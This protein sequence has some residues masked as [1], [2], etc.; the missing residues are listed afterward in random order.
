MTNKK[1]TLTTDRVIYDVRDKQ[2][3][4]GWRRRR[5]RSRGKE[6]HRRSDRVVRDA[7]APS[8]RVALWKKPRVLKT[9]QSSRHR[10]Q[11]T[12]FE[13]VFL[14]AKRK[15]RRGVRLSTRADPLSLSLFSSLSSC[16]GYTRRANT[17]GNVHVQ[18]VHYRVLLNPKIQLDLFATVG[19]VLVHRY[20]LGSLN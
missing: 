12:V 6:I 4:R 1:T 15:T 11:P 7:G 2:H 19:G 13:H 17:G 18:R 16:S 8:R 20:I 9:T 10:R 14:R 3:H 5:G